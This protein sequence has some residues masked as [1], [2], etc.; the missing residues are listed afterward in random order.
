MGVELKKYLCILVSDQLDRLSYLALGYLSVLLRDGFNSP[1]K[2]G[3]FAWQQ[4][5][6]PWQFSLCYLAPNRID[7]SAITDDTNIY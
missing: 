2:K 3:P 4:V 5:S 6:S 7:A 1:Q